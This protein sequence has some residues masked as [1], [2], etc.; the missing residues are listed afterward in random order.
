MAVEALQEG[1][2]LGQLAAAPSAPEAK[3]GAIEAFA[4]AA[5][6]KPPAS[7]RPEEDINT[8]QMVVIA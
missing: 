5:R 7:W 4:R 3:D 2:R 6:T 8:Y 1:A